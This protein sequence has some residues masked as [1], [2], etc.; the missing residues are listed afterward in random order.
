MGSLISWR[1]F[2]CGT[3]YSPKLKPDRVLGEWPGRC[4]NPHQ[5]KWMGRWFS[6]ATCFS[7]A[8]PLSTSSPWGAG[9]HLLGP[10]ALILLSVNYTNGI[11][12]GKAVNRSTSPMGR[13]LP[14]THFTARTLHHTWGG[15]QGLAEP[16]AW[17]RVALFGT[18]PRTKNQCYCVISNYC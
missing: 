3:V 11:L 5:A 4:W 16:D 12:S 18:R 10:R 9:M 15:E 6:K 7:W 8:S 1:S 17:K 14:S 13:G 2:A